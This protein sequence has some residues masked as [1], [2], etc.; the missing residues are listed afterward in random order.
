MPFLLECRV[1]T[2][3]AL[4]VGNLSRILG[5]D[6]RRHYARPLAYCLA[7]G[8]LEDGGDRLGITR[9][10]FRH[11]GAVFS[12]FYAPQG[13]NRLSQGCLP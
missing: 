11:Y 1:G 4:S 12:L 13:K 8:L 7:N 5:C 6:A 2:P 10:G 3:T 9:E